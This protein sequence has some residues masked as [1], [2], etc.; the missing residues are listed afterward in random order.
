MNPEAKMKRRSRAEWQALIEKQEQSGV[1]QEAFCEQQGVNVGTFRWWKK[2]LGK[3]E[4]PYVEL[5]LPAASKSEVTVTLPC[6]TIF[7][8][9][10]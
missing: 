2:Q 5:S 10:Y 1:T 4:K 8:F 7:S 9:S 3:E 6:G